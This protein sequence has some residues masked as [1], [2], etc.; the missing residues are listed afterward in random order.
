MSDY[1][2]GY[3]YGTKDVSSS[4]VFHLAGWSEHIMDFMSWVEKENQLVEFVNKTE[5]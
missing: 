3:G 1:G 4:K 5:I 2:K